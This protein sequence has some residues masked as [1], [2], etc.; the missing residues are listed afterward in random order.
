MRRCLSQVEHTDMVRKVD[1]LGRIGIPV[2]LR[3][4]LNI[5]MSDD[6]EIFF[7]DDCIIFKKYQPIKICMITGQISDQ[8]IELAHGKIVLSPEGVKRLLD[9]LKNDVFS[10]S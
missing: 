6:I 2:K 5:E 9:E 4:E 8:N 1:R 3:R 10:K 7:Q